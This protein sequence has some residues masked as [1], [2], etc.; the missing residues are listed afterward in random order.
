MPNT[1]SDASPQDGERMLI[2]HFVFEF[3]SFSPHI[4]FVLHSNIQHHSHLT[5]HPLQTLL[6]TSPNTPFPYRLNIITYLTCI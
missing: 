1:D 2:V 5:T 4:S 3:L 6:H